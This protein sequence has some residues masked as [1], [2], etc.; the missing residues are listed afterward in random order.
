MIYLITAIQIAGIMIAC[1]AVPSKA[2]AFIVISALIVT[3][4]YFGSLYGAHLGKQ[5]GF[6]RGYR[7]G[8]EDYR[9]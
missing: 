8:R 6:A 3:S 1:F 2:T 4:A 9:A 5:Y 7:K